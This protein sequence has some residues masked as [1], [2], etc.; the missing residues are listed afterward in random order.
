[1]T[2]LFHLWILT[3][4]RN[5]LELGLLAAPLIVVTASSA[6]RWSL[7][8]VDRNVWVLVV[9]VRAIGGTQWRA[10]L[11]GPRAR[12]EQPTSPLTPWTTSALERWGTSQHRTITECPRVPSRNSSRCRLLGSKTPRNLPRKDP[13]MRLLTTRKIETFHQKTMKKSPYM[14]QQRDLS[15]RSRAAIPMELVAGYLPQGRA[16]L[17]IWL[18]QGRVSDFRT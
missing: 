5:L 15:R 9:A 6:R 7:E 8:Q 12:S 3:L 14:S 13:W 2:Q 11:R 17:R 10:Q 4:V 1:M 18:T 16:A